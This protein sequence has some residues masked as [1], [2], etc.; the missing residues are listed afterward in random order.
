MNESGVRPPRARR[1]VR[2]L[3]RGISTLAAGM[4]LFILVASLLTEPVSWGDPEGTALSV[5]ILLSA[6]G[7]GGGWR[8]ERFGGAW[9]TAV[10]IAFCTFAYLSAGSNKGLAVLVSGFPFL[11]AG[12]LYLLWCSWG[13]RAEA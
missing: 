5:L 3:A 6:V 9:L 4:W 2:W 11:L 1:V 10:G 8:S 7:V 13:R 12:L